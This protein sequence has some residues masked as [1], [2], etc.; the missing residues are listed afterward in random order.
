M[1]ESTGARAGRKSLAGGQQGRSPRFT[2]ALSPAD[3]ET[4]DAMGGTRSDAIRALIE[5]RRQQRGKVVVALPRAQALAA[6]IAIEWYRDGALGLVADGDLR[7]AQDAAVAIAE[8][9]S[10]AAEQR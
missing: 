5:Q 8:A 6:L 1:T 9:L 10:D 3:M 2:V 7:V 4:L